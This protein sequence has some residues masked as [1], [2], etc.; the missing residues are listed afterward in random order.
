M[1]FAFLRFEARSGLHHALAVAAFLCSGGAAWAGTPPIVHD[2]FVDGS[3]RRAP[4]MVVIPRLAGSV[5]G[6]PQ[7]RG[8]D[9]S[10]LRH[11]VTLSPYAIGQTE[12]SNAEFA[13]FLTDAG[14]ADASGTAWF[15]PDVTREIVAN[16][17]IFTAVPGSE[18]RP[19]AGM[20]WHAARA[21]AAWLSRKTGASYMLP[22]GAQWEMAARSGTR[23]TW[24]WGDTDDTS[25]YR[26]IASAERH[27]ADA[28]AYPANPWGIYGTSGNV[29][30]W[31]LDCH[32]ERGPL[33]LGSRDPVMF[34]ERCETPEIRGGSFR[35]GGEYSRPA[36][37]SNAMSETKA[38]VLG[39]RVVRRIDPPKG[40]ATK[41][42]LQLTWRH[43]GKSASAMAVFRMAEGDPVIASVPDGALA[44]PAG[45]VM[46]LQLFDPISGLTLFDA[47]V[48]T[49]GTLVLP[50]PVRLQGRVHG[51]ASEAP[52]RVRVGSG[53]RQPPLER[54]LDAT[55]SQAPRDGRMRSVLGIA[56]PASPSVWE[57]AELEGDAFDTG[58]LLAADRPQIV[59]FDT[60]GRVAVKDVAL[61]AYLAAHAT[62]D[63]GRVVLRASTSLDIRAAAPAPD[64]PVALSLGVRRV[65]IDARERAEAGLLLSA[66]DQI[67]P[68]LFDFLVLD[69]G[70][71]MSHRGKL[72]L[73]P[74]P[75]FR[76]ITLLARDGFGAADE[77][78]TVTLRPGASA[79]IRIGAGKGGTVRTARD[80]VLRGRVTWQGGAAVVD[81][82]VVVSDYPVRRETRTDAAGM[83]AVT[84]I[85]RSAKVTVLVDA[86]KSSIGAPSMQIFH[87]VAVSDIAELALPVVQPATSQL[88]GIE[89][90]METAGLGNCT[91]VNDAQY[92]SR[93]YLVQD[94]SLTV[95]D[96]GYRLITLDVNS[97]IA[98]FSVC[99]QSKS[100]AFWWARSPFNVQVGPGVEID[101]EISDCPDNCKPGCIHYQAKL[102]PMSDTVKGVELQVNNKNGFA[103]GQGVQ[104]L[105]SPP[106]PF[107]EFLDPTPLL[108]NAKGQIEMCDVNA[109]PVQAY[110]EGNL[111]T[112]DCPINLRV[113]LIRLGSACEKMDLKNGR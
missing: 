76:R 53:I 4:A 50:E 25:R 70:I 77:E 7:D 55:G 110:Y 48:P 69:H 41:G 21:Y 1:R 11:D 26:S 78:R 37:R 91:P 93:S 103:V 45:R 80:G 74:M 14:N 8:Y 2:V 106:G 63:A 36:F 94:G 6:R 111:G 97:S 47:A 67:N 73:G 72:H 39:F 83:F 87:D 88:A 85:L 56:L 113:P 71:V 82:R 13:L 79:S 61:P 62:L 10:E 54:W 84:G 89:M 35:D 19:A 109:N 107:A 32:T 90:P 43:S 99:Q 16:G 96:G 12:V 64:V 22:T 42:T 29:W 9:L 17:A 98:K 92:G 66:L 49:S 86:A 101:V 3:A 51:A 28:R 59:A 18:S 40:L 34:D 65:E 27:A 95:D 102:G 105:F 57:D 100:L 60:A 44:L 20:S 81:A 46:T 5:G 38:D 108:T 75:H 33:V 30:E 15:D 31:M 58:W 68:R 112:T 24:W 52:L 23:T 104:L